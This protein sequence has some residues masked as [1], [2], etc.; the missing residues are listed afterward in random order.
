MINF[1]PLSGARPRRCAVIGGDAN[2]DGGNAQLYIPQPWC[3]AHDTS[4]PA[5]PSSRTS[6]SGGASPD[7]RMSTN[8]SAVLIVFALLRTCQQALALEPH[9]VQ[10]KQGI[11][12]KRRLSLQSTGERK[13]PTHTHTRTHDPGSANVHW[14]IGR[15]SLC[16]HLS[17]EKNVLW[18]SWWP[19]LVNILL[20]EKWINNAN[21]R[22]LLI[23]PADYNLLPQHYDSTKYY[24]FQVAFCSWIRRCWSDHS[25]LET[26][27]LFM[28]FY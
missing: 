8:L 9:D 25:R 10:D 7:W 28:Q 16:T 2:L 22:I 3:R 27:I 1:W 19:P 13:R 18:N 5:A 14:N 26:N 4:V 21:S 23:S 6:R 11:Q 20:L 12:V 15:L 24:N 17:T